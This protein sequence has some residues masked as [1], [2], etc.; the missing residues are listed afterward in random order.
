VPL[1]QL[2]GEC[3]ALGSSTAVSGLARAAHKVLMEV[4]AD[5]W[6]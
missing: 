5:R 6:D 1:S 2:Q 4:A 3:A